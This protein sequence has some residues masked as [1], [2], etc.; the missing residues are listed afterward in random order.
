[1]E[2]NVKSS[3]EQERALIAGFIRS[4]RNKGS[5]L[6]IAERIENPGSKS[7]LR[8][9]TIRYGASPEKKWMI[10]EIDD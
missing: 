2:K 5:G 8:S 4:P 6:H 7:G 9:W 1:M 10:V 3:I